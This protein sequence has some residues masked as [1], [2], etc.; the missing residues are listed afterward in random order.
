M[1]ISPFLPPTSTSTGG[2]G[3]GGTGGYS[4]GSGR[5]SVQAPARPR[6]F[7]W[8]LPYSATQGC[9]G[10]SQGRGMVS[11]PLPP[12]YPPYHGWGPWQVYPRGWLP[13]GPVRS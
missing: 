6:P 1:A 7:P 11:T 3:G 5:V 8:P 4:G 12:Y 10:V 2:A 9:I 13:W